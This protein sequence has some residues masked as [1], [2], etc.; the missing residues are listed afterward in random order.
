MRVIGMLLG[1]P[2][3]DQVAVR[4]KDTRSDILDVIKAGVE[5]P[6]GVILF[7]RTG[8]CTRCTAG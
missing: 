6:A 5:L 2:E 8:R 4:N 3:Q 7:S 1:I